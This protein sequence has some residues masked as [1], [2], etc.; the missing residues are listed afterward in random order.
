[1]LATRLCRT[2]LPF[3]N[4]QRQSLAGPGPFRFA[5]AVILTGLML[6]KGSPV[7]AQSSVCDGAQCPEDEP[8][9]VQNLA[10]STTDTADSITV[11]W[12]FPDTG[13]RPDKFVVYVGKAGSGRQSGKKKVPRNL[14]KTSVTFKNLTP[15]KVYK[16]WVQAQN[17][18]GKGA[19]S[20]ATIRLNSKVLPGP[21]R[22]LDVV[23]MH[24]MAIVTWDSPETGGQPWSYIV[25]L[26]RKGAGIGTGRTKTPRARDTFTMVTFYELIDGDYRIWVRAQN[27]AGKGARVR[28]TFSLSE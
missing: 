12:D 3:A 20:Q 27:K 26:K 10:L 16:V 17:I 21:I 14:H 18:V 7:L 11:T 1:M 23:S 5:L 9:V 13:G 22:N 19:W 4:S 25:H 28:D 6:W 2:L 8:G 24:G 15:G